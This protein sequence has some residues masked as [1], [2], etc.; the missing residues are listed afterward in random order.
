MTYT[1]PE[2]TSGSEEEKDVE[3]IPNE[4]FR[5]NLMFHG[6]NLYRRDLCD[7]DGYP[8]EDYNGNALHVYNRSMADAFNNKSIRLIHKV[9]P[10][11]RFFIT[12]KEQYTRFCEDRS[13]GWKSTLPGIVY[14][15]YDDGDCDY[16]HPH[17]RGANLRYYH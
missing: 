4:L 16:T 2:Y 13:K 6:S 11:Y 9:E 5:V 10:G 3:F 14:H 15:V 12:S 1:D 7:L 8:L 17:F